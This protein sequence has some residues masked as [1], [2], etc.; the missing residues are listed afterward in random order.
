MSKHY[1]INSVGV[2]AQNVQIAQSK[3]PP[4]G[5]FESHINGNIAIELGIPQ[6]PMYRA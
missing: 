2:I 1:I 6:N 3:W 4:G 5:H